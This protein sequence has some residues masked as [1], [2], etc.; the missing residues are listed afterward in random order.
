MIESAERRSQFLGVV[1]S[2]MTLVS[3]HYGL[4]VH[5]SQVTR[6]DENAQ[7]LLLWTSS[8]TL[9]PALAF[10]MLSVCL[11]IAR[12]VQLRRQV[13][14]AYG[15]AIATASWAVITMFMFAFQCHL[16]HPWHIT[17]PFGEHCAGL[18][19]RYVATDMCKAALEFA[20]ITASIIMVWDL[21]MRLEP[22]ITVCALFGL[23]L[24]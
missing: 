11:L 6:H 5:Q 9:T 14:V 21:H 13:W 20:N 8:L 4:G 10:S 1:H 23:R 19:H 24:L 7:Q 16:P 17:R 15:I 22:K 2:V 12:I 18:W 3:I